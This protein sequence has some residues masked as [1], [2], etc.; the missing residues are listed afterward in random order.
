MTVLSHYWTGLN[1][2][3]TVLVEFDVFVHKLQGLKLICLRLEKKKT[4]RQRL[5]LNDMSKS[6]YTGVT[7]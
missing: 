5:V 1:A 3:A 2:A 7:R 6:M 4:C